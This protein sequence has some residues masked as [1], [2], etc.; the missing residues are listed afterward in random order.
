MDT[1]KIYPWYFALAAVLI[2]FLLCFLPGILGLFYSLTDWNAYSKDINFIG[3]KN[4]IQVF[5]GGSQYV[6]F[7]GNTLSFTAITTVLKTVSGLAMAMLLTHQLIKIR[8][9][10]RLVIF[11]PQVM[12]YLVVGLVFK[13]LLHPSTGFVNNLLREAGLGFMAK[14]WLTDLSLVFGTVM[15]V[16]TWKGAGYIMVVMIAALQAI[17]PTYYEAAAIDG[18]S[19]WKQFKYITLPLLKPIL[20][21]VTVLNVTYGLRVF[22]MVYALTN[23]GPGNATGVINT[24]VYKEFSKGNYAMGTTLSSVLFLFI[25][26]TL[27]FIIKAMESREVDF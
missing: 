10:H 18:A 22:D 24:A 7:I 20:V 14:N 5:K 3:M 2:Y 8:N 27:Y 4:Y 21:N 6:A 11:S 25:L 15:T 1:K 17:S 9:F 16:D 26:A 12:S 23:G 13:S 19:Y